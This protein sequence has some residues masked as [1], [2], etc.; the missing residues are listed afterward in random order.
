M[1]ASLFVPLG[2]SSLAF[3]LAREK[4]HLFWT[5]LPLSPL[6]P[7]LLGVLGEAH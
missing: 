3:P 7:S 6:A 5:L 1:G 2:T 4:F